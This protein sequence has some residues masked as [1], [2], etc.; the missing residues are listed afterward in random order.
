MTT[1]TE[2]KV[3]KAYLKSHMLSVFRELEQ[4]GTELIVTDYGKPVLRIVPIRVKK[5]P[6]D[7]FADVRGKIMLNEKALL[8]PVKT[9]D[10]S[11]KDDII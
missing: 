6:E 8:S 5:K 10:Y 4:E 1:V 9:S 3:S 7:V 11:L 2:N